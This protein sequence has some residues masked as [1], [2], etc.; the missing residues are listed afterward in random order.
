MISETFY[1]LN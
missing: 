1:I